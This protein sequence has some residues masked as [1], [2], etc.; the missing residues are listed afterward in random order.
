MLLQKGK[1]FIHYFLT[2]PVAVEPCKINPIGN[3]FD[4][5]KIPDTVNPSQDSCIAD[6]PALFHTVQRIPQCFRTHQFQSLCHSQKASCQLSRI[7]NRLIRLLQKR[8][9][10][11]PVGSGDHF[12][13]QS[14]SNLNGRI[15]QSAGSAP[16]QQG[17]GRLQIQ[18]F[19]KRPPG[20]K[21]SLWHSGKFYPGKR[22]NNGKH[23]MNRQESILSIASIET[24][25]HAA[26]KG[27]HFLPLFK[28]TVRRICNLSHTF[29]A[30]D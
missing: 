1:D 2:G 30:G 11:F 21:V 7:Q 25:P 5:I 6:D 10:L 14:L 15:A 13:A 26:H 19:K 20:G 27:C 18:S 3:E 16:D 24:P 23:M 4:R 12:A 17:I 29:N 28:G 9:L 22:R 8:Q